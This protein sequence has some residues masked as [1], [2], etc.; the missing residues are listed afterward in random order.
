MTT[1]ATPIEADNVLLETTEP[2]TSAQKAMFAYFGVNAKI[3][4]PLRILNPGRISIGDY[5]AVRE[6]CHWNAFADL[7]FLM[8]YIDPAY[9]GDFDAAAYSYD[10]KI[11]IARECQIGRFSFMSCTNRIAIERNVVISE[12]VFVGDNNHSFSHPH[13]PIMQQPNKPGDP[14]VIGLGSWIASGAAVLSGARLGANSVVGANAVVHAGDYPSHA[15]IAAPAATVLYRRHSN[16][17]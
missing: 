6:G 2:L 4:P 17:D 13:V 5:T 8:R 15:V 16:D 11:E 14:V 10:S 12:R 3:L 1:P 7:S 9:A